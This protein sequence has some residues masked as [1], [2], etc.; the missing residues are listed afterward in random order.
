MYGNPIDRITINATIKFEILLSMNSLVM[1]MKIEKQALTSID[2]IVLLIINSLYLITS[3]LNIIFDIL[4]V[5]S[6]ELPIPPIIV[7]IANTIAKT[8]KNPIIVLKI[9]DNTFRLKIEFLLIGVSF[10]ISIIFLFLDNKLP[11]IQADNNV[12]IILNFV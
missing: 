6:C 9:L 3:A 12:T 2:N 8:I 11:N 7:P 1:F 4:I 5:G 10:C